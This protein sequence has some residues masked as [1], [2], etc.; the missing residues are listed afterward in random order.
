MPFKENDPAQR[1]EMEEIGFTILAS[2]MN[3]G[4]GFGVIGIAAL[5]F[6]LSQ[7]G[8]IPYFYH[9]AAA[10]LLLIFSHFFVLPVLRKKW[11]ATNQLVRWGNLQIWFHALFGLLWGLPGVLYF[12]GDPVRLVILF[13]L[14]IALLM[15]AAIG[16]AIYLP[17][18][19]AFSVTL[20][21]P[22]SVMAVMHD[23]AIA[24]YQAIA[25]VIIAACA[26][27]YSY[28]FNRAQWESI[29]MRFENARLNEDLTEQRV[30][31]RTRV[32]EASN[33]HK[34]EFLATVSHEI[35]TP[36]NAI[37]GMSGLLLDT[38]LNAEQRDF[39]NT[40]RDSGDALLTI[41]N[42]ILDYSKIEAGKMEMETQPFDL[43]D[44]VE[45]ALDLV[46]AQ[47]AAKHLDLAYVF[48]G[49]IPTAIAG[50]VT[51]VR[52]I[53]L[54][55]LANAVKFTETGEVVVTIS[56]YAAP[57]NTNDQVSG[58][59]T[60]ELSADNMLQIAV[61]D[62]GIGLG[63]EVISRLFQSFSQAD[64]ST[65]RKFGGTGLGLAISK[66]LTE[67]MGGQMW[68]HSDGP[69]R[70][71][72]FYFSLR[73]PT[74][75]LHSTNRRDFI[76]TQPILKGKRILVV[77]DNATNRRILALQAAKWG[78]VAEDTESPM[79]ALDMLKNTR[80][81]EQTADLHAHSNTV[82]DLAIID[83]HMPVMDG[84]TLAREIRAQGFTLPLILFSSLGR[85]EDNLDLFAAIVSKPLRQSQLFD[86]LATLL[87]PHESFTQYL[88]PVKPRIDPNTSTLHPLRILVVEDNVVNQKLAL[89]LLQQL[90]YR[91]DLASNG[92]EA[93]E[94][95]ARQTYDVILMDVQMPEMDGLE[96]ARRITERWPATNRPNIIAM[97]AN[98]MHGDKEA[99]LAAGMSDYITKPIRIDALV[100]ALMQVPAQKEPQNDAPH[101]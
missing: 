42:D 19:V 37:I 31:E 81:I 16:S 20:V 85:R 91:A 45:S 43:R 78:M 88:P 67:L 3:A 71:S 65:T 21:L 73:A 4:I 84:A 60:H 79:Q 51:R 95:V 87:E 56:A 82:F 14:V 7:Q 47:A 48:E 34:S 59:T 22:M 100:E 1:Q 64:N 12:S 13:V 74:A 89:R 6:A 32:L 52:Q 29:K 62:T 61:R 93:I 70:G 86:T 94:S 28:K 90:G 54:N 50:D 44:C 63:E 24:H 96:A 49:E 39:A 53:L 35:R 23:I 101:N 10:L 33:R 66:K 68:V 98:A 57:I 11:Q 92:V 58:A 80:N 17:A 97:T 76:G 69:G 26:A 8:P 41:I 9:W 5:G 77:D 15:S 36:M 46:S 40:I 99:C 72:T 2:N 83:M 25:I 27:A 75:K 55:L 30:Q 38:P 18:S